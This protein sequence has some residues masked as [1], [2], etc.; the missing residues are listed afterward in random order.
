MRG[1]PP[2]G[3]G[4]YMR[5][6][7]AV[8]ERQPSLHEKKPENLNSIGIS[9]GNRTHPRPHAAAS[10]RGPLWRPPPMRGP[11]NSRRDSCFRASLPPS[12]RKNLKPRIMGA[13]GI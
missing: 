2:P 12:I 9:F 10:P 8:P 1:I 13:A 5:P 11:E 3:A 4:G 7:M 6:G